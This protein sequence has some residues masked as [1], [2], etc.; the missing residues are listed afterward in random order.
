MQIDGGKDWVDSI[1]EIPFDGDAAIGHDFLHFFASQIEVF[2]KIV[3]DIAYNYPKSIRT[4]I[5]L[6]MGSGNSFI[7]FYTSEKLLL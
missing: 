1:E 3:H 4:Y 2:V 7:D 5:A 6:F